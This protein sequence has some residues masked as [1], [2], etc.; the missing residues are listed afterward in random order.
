MEV[1]KALTEQR[2]IRI[3]KKK[4]EF[5][6]SLLRRYGKTKEP[7]LLS[8]NNAKASSI[9]L[10]H[11]EGRFWLVMTRFSLK[12]HIKMFVRRENA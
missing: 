12:S 11:T 8:S 3:S 7:D 9:Y 2:F 10:H 4:K 6:R 1:R 5:S